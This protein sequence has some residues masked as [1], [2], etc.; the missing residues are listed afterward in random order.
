MIQTTNVLNVYKTFVT[1]N[2]PITS[3]IV[4]ITTENLLNIERE[5][6]YEEKLL[7]LK[8]ILNDIPEES[9]LLFNERINSLQQQ[10]QDIFDEENGKLL[11]NMLLKNFSNNKKNNERK[12]KEGDILN[13]KKKTVSK[14]N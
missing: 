10:Q 1:K 3:N 4:K 2:L 9:F 13:N 8:K 14:N 7:S 5:K 11:F 6:K 12:S